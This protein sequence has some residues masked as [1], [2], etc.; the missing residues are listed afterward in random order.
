M[1]NYEVYDLNAELAFLC[2]MI[3]QYGNKFTILENDLKSE[4]FYDARHR[5][6]FNAIYELLERYDKI[7]TVILINHLSSRNQLE[8][9][10]GVNYIEGITNAFFG[11]VEVNKYAQIIREKAIIRELI[12]KTKELSVKASQSTSLN[13][14]LDE[15]EN[16]IYNLGKYRLSSDFKSFKDVIKNVVEDIK[17]KRKN[18]DVK[19]VKTGFKKLDSITNGFQKGDLVILAA[20]PAIGKTAFALNLAY[21]IAR[22]NSLES[23]AI[24]SLEMSDEQLVGR[25]LS[26]ESQV[27]SNKIRAAML[28]NNEL[29]SLVES[30]EMLSQIPIAIDDTA[31]I[32]T[33]DILAKCR[34]LK[35][36]AGLSCIII[37]YIQLISSRRSGES[38]QVEVSEISRSL[39]IMARELKVPVIALSQLSRGVESRE[40][41]RPRLSDLR[42][43]GAIEQD[44]DIV[45]FLYREDYYEKKD[46]DISL[47]ELDIAKHRNGSIGNIKLAF[48]KSTS[49]FS[50]YDY[51]ANQ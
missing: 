49:T 10:G 19:G 14:T 3:L 12:A 16:M 26:V 17:A 31:S 1:E 44:A 23:V 45:M 35:D 20:R 51:E 22:Y 36:K 8:E 24:F 18:I 41:K 48:K 40:D 30:A 50:E 2:N 43:S 9:A 4:Y 46:N 5:I 37:D 33:S 15:A 38:R 42:E 13:E 28:N 27:E 32:R 47:V 39:K 25:L 11:D 34:K 6:I 7:D 29:A 21:R